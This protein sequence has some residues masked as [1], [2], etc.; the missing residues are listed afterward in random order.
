MVHNEER[1]LDG[2]IIS[3]GEEVTLALEVMQ[4]LREKGYDLRVISMPSIERYNNLSKEEKEELLPLGIKKFVIEKGSGYSWYQFVY[5]DNYL[6]T[7]DR[8]G[9]SGKVEEI[10]SFYGFTK[11]EISL[12]IESLLK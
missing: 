4:L 5:K 1:K 2:V 8:F 10:N 9:A 11:E 3:T 6:F 7:L 12:K